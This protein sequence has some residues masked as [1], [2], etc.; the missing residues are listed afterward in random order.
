VDLRV[1]ARYPFLKASATYV[2]RSG[3]T[4]DDLVADETTYGSVRARGKERVREALEGRQVR[5]RPMAG[6]A[7]WQRELLS[8]PVARMLV[9]AVADPYLVRRYALGEAVLAN[10][11]LAA[12][13]PAFLAVV[14]EDLGVDLRPDDGRV[15]MHFTDFL[16]HSSAMRGKEWKLIN[17][18]VE[19]G[20]VL[21]P[22]DRAARVLR[23]AIQGK[24]EAELPLPVN[25]LILRTFREE[26]REL[27][28]LVAD[29]KATFQAEAIGKVTITR[30]PPCMY[31][32]LAMIQ[33]HENVPHLGRFAIVSFLHHIGVGNEEI[34][35]VFGDVP[36]FAVDVTRYQIDH[37]TGTI[38]ATEYTPPE[39]ATMKSY[40]LCPGPDDLCLTIRHPLAYYRKKPR[41]KPIGAPTSPPPAGPP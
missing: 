35:R 30:F 37:I 7:D 1:L 28:T 9:S 34:F 17:Q 29:R 24:I 21:L 3:H 26:V 32:L 10:A 40:G 25:D 19:A 8:Y 11:R 31:Q 22:K 27:R 39:C 33:N 16:R 13:P 41:W 23:N 18:R 5:D 36:D 15:R 4:L 12:E 14:A 2:R 20:Y 38:S 6:E